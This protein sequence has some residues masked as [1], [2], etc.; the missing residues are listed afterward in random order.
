MCSLQEL[1]AQGCLA[2]VCISGRVRRTGV[3]G[4]IPPQH[5]RR[6]GGTAACGL[7]P[8]MRLA[9]GFADSDVGWGKGVAGCRF[10][11]QDSFDVARGTARAPSPFVRLSTWF[12]MSVRTR[13]IGAA[14]CSASSAPQAPVA[15]APCANG[16]ECRAL[17][18]PLPVSPAGTFRLREE[19][20]RPQ[21]R[22]NAGCAS[23]STG[24][25][26]AWLA[27][28]LGPSILRQALRQAQ[29]IAQDTRRLRM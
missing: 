9:G 27:G 15:P 18:V 7:P 17:F 21:G 4:S 16:W 13:R 2:T 25:S 14:E 1:Q 6:A 23:V 22:S 10:F 11:G 29:H 5:R 24:F 19:C 12:R 8:Y 26:H 28:G 3:G 20:R